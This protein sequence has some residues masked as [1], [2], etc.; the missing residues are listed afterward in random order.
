M[1]DIENVI[2]D[3]NVAKIIL[4]N[5]QMLT[6]EM[7]V[8]IGQAV[9]SALDLLKEQKAIVRCKYCKHKTR[10]ICNKIEFWECNHIRYEKTKCGVSDDWFCAD[11]E[12][13]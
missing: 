7:C 4:C 8:R 12:R 5:T 11:G 13:R 3:L 2:N 10:G 6:P 1:S 9:T